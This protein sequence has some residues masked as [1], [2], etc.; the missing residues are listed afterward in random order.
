MKKKIIFFLVVCLLFVGKVSAQTETQLFGAGVSAATNGF[1]ANAYWQPVDKWK[2]ALAGEFFPQLSIDKTINEGSVSVDMNAKYKTG[3]V[4]VTGGYQF[5]SWM[6][7]TA[8]LGINFFKASAIGSPQSMK[9]GDITLSPETIGGLNVNI[10]SGAT[11]SPYL[12][13]GFGR[14]LPTEK[15]VGVGVEIG[16]YYMGSPQLEIDATGMLEGTGD[17]EHVQAL[18]DEFSQFKFYP[19]I[20]LN[21]TFNV[22]SM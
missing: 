11:V 15:L 20:K 14:Q 22:F 21:V 6:Y 5:L 10:K 12:A 19:M 4:F 9:Y 2:V 3:G 17:P 8:G 16:A 13:I 18:Q 7:A 1:G